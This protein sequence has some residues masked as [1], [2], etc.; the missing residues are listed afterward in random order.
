MHHLNIIIKKNFVFKNLNFKI[1]KGQFIG[2]KGE[3]DQVNLLF[4]TCY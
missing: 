2:I 3:S 1:K 4:L